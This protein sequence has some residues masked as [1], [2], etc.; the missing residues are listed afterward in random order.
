[1][2]IPKLFHFVFFGFTDF[3]YI[4]YLSIITCYIIHKPDIIY[5]YY[6]HLPDEN[7]ATKWWKKIQ[8][9]ITLEY[10]ELPTSIFGMPVKKYQHMADIIRLE[11][12][13]ERGGVYL[14]LDVV[15]LRPFNHLYNEKCVLGMKCPGT[16]YEGLCNAVILAEPSSFFL[17]TWY[18]EYKSFKSHRWDYH[19]VKLPLLLSRLYN[20][21][22]NLI[23]LKCQTQSLIHS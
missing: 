12:L 21:Y 3:T 14:D 19:S 16:K 22:L 7:N 11:K 2:T 23:N 9:I 6:H 10:V 15:S 13:I 8:H 17:K 4:H 20:K 1:M 5:L 18:L